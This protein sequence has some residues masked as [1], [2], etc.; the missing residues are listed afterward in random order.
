MVGRVRNLSLAQIYP[1][2]SGDVNVNT[3]GNPDC[4][5]YGVALRMGRRRSRGNTNGSNSAAAGLGDY[6]LG[7][8][9]DGEQRVSSAFEYAL[10]PHRWIDARSMQCQHVAGSGTCGTNFEILSNE[11]LVAEIE[12]LRNMNGVLDGPRCRA[13]GAAYLENPDEFILNG[14]NGKKPVRGHGEGGVEKPL[15]VRLI[16]RPCRGRPGSRFSV[17]LD[18]LRQKSTAQ[19]ASILKA[20]VNGGG[21]QKVR[22]MILAVEG[23]NCGVA[24]V[25]DRLFW[26]EKTLLAYEHEQLRR[27]KARVEASGQRVYNH[28]AHDDIALNVNWETSEDRRLTTLNCSTTADVKSGYVY[29]IDVDFDPTI[30]PADFIA[31]VFGEPDEPRRHLNKSYTNLAGDT[32]THPL[33]SFQRETGRLDERNLFA[34][35]AHQHS[36]FLSQKLPLLAGD[37]L[38]KRRIEREVSARIDLIDELRL[39]YFAFPATQRDTSRTPFS[40]IMTRDIYTKAAHLH[41]VKEMLPRGAIKLVTE[42]EATLPRIIPHIFHDHIAADDFTWLAIGFDKEATKPKRQRRI[43][44]YKQA[45]SVFMFALHAS[46]PDAAERMSTPDQVRAFIARF[47]STATQTHAGVT[48]GPIQSSNYQQRWMPQIWVH[49]PVETHGESL[50]IVGLPLPRRSLRTSLLGLPFSTDVQTLD[51]RDK[52][53]IARHVFDATLQPV[54]AFFNALRE[55]LSPARRAGG[56]S[57]RG[58]ASFVNGAFYNPRALIAL[59]NIFRVHYNWFEPR[60]YVTAGVSELGT[61]E[62][63]RGTTVV[64]IP[65]TDELI[66]VETKAERRPIKRTPAMRLGAHQVADDEANPDPPDPLRVLYRPWI[67]AGTPVWD[68]FETPGVDQRRRRSA[69]VR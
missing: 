28:L 48:T 29:R 14:A 13:C 69:R 8:S 56:R 27:W 24:R 2:P 43:S 6:K 38:T 64:R 1:P 10:D 21:I 22:R 44:D 4:G 20:F 60:P 68:K 31:Q 54:S 66:E 59:L 17:T 58:G 12:R 18:H 25:Y 41:L 53:R 9:V 3:C 19:N 62:V 23:R 47:M 11:H 52:E 51:D 65:G 26:L 45:F 34:A 57:A 61:V 40:G 32:F 36:L 37:D 33:M 15:R 39:N 55:R 63:E 49:S 30:N 46:D 35:A 42:Q 7:S 16:H 50:K 67:Y 5:N